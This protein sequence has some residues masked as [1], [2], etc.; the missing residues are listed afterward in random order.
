[1]YKPCGVRQDLSVSSQH[2]MIEVSTGQVPFA[3]TDAKPAFGVA[4][5]TFRLHVA[6]RFP[7]VGRSCSAASAVPAAA[8]AVSPRRS[9]PQ[10]GRRS[11][12]CTGEHGP[13]AGAARAAEI[14]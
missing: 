14:A 2:L 6:E 12:R 9:E 7:A 4:L 8:D 13:V 5:S 3:A 10:Q 1:M 11:S